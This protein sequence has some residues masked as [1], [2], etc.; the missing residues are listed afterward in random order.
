MGLAIAYGRPFVLALCLKI[1]QDCLSFLQPQ[2]LRRLLTFITEHQEAHEGL[3]AE[4]P[5][6]MIGLSLAFLMF[7]TSI[8]QTTIL[9]QVQPPVLILSWSTD[10]RGDSISKGSMK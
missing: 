1:V 5:T 4:R 2:L 6:P 8:F 7:F 9:H 10:W 3:L